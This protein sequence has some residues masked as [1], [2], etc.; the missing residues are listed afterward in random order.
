LKAQGMDSGSNSKI[1][2][3]MFGLPETLE[4]KVK[5]DPDAWKFHLESNLFLAN[6]RS[7]IMVLIDKLSPVN[8]WMP[9]YLCPVMI[10]VI[11]Q[12]KTILNFYEVKYDL[13]IT[14][15]DWID[16]V[17]K[18]DLVLFIDY[19]GFPLDSDVAA[20]VKKQ[21]G[22]VV[23]D[24]CQAL[25][26][27]HVGQHSDFIIFSPRKFIGVPDGGVLVSCCDV[28][29]GDVEVVSPSAKWWLSILDATI[30]RREFDRCGGQRRWLGLCQ[31]AEAS[32]PCGRY[33]MSD[34]SKGLLFNA[35]DYSFITMRRRENYAFLV[36]ELIDLAL[37]KTLPQDVVPLGFP[38]IHPQ[39]DLLR[40]AL[41]EHEIYPPVHWPICGAT[42]DIFAESHRLA[43]QVM[44]LP[45]DQRYSVATMKHMVQIILNTLDIFR[46]DAIA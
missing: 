23:E 36:T 17:Q 9:S 21:G 6:G 40:K 38:I 19:F 7:G 45:C 24:A 3:S 26:S 32:M 2:G 14:A 33:S 27:S 8:V 16:Q 25:L 41:F 12:K 4:P 46:E 34:L 42:P 18:G 31:E 10:D 43:E 35:F 15:T 37:I 39:R 29:F 44:T 1:I 13:K 22:W 11:D 5:T 20:L 30:N 28:T